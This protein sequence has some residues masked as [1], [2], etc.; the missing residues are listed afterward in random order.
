MVASLITLYSYLL[1]NRTKTIQ[2]V[3]LWTQAQIEDLRS[4]HSHNLM[5]ICFITFQYPVHSYCWSGQEW[6]EFWLSGLREMIR[7]TWSFPQSGADMP[8]TLSFLTASLLIWTKMVRI[9]NLQA[10]KYDHIYNLVIPIIWYRY[11]HYGRAIRH[12]YCWIVYNNMF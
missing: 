11:A 8:I 2:I 3:I 7:I 5:Q 6:S 4:G 1:L 10:F 9:L 12:L